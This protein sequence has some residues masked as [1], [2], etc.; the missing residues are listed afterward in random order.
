MRR[1]SFRRPFRRMTRGPSAFAPSRASGGR[2]ITWEQLALGVDLVTGIL[3]TPNPNVA[4]GERFR[5]IEPGNITRGTVT[6][7]RIRGSIAIRQPNEIAN[8]V[9][10]W[11]WGIQLVPLR[12]GVIEAV[13]MLSL[14]NT[15][16]LENNRWLWRRSDYTFLEGTGQQLM[17]NNSHEVDVKSKRRYA[18]DE[19]GLILQCFTNQAGADFANNF[20][21]VDLRALYATGDGL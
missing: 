6:L 4:A 11:R 8:N 18:R 7:L 16:D 12:N 1:R 9:T 2:S 17:Y 5:V 20:A 21:A 10:M 19:W 3:P 15:A 13:S 14:N